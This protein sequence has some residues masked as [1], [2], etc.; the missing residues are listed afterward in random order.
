MEELIELA[1]PRA[2]GLDAELARRQKW[3]LARRWMEES[4]DETE[5]KVVSLHFGDEMPMDAITRLLQLSN[6]SGAKAFVVSARRKLQESA[7]RWKSRQESAR[8]R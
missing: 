6:P 8:E 5:R 3:D 4:L 2:E 1:D 7:R